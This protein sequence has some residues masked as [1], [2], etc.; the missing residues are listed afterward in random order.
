M[1]WGRFTAVG[2]AEAEAVTEAIVAEV[3]AA[4]RQAFSGPELRALLMLGGYGRGEGGVDRSGP[5]ERPHNNLDFLIVAEDSEGKRL[6]EL[7]ARLAATVAPIVQKHGI[8]MDTGATTVGR[9]RRAPSL[10]LWY[11][12]RFGHKTILG[13]ADLMPGMTHFRL[14]RIPAWDARNLLTNRGTLLLINAAVLEQDRPLD[15]ERRRLLVRHVMKA[16][17]GY[18]DALLFFLGDFHWSYLEKRRRMGLQAAVSPEFRALYDE[19]AG[20]RF[21]PRYEPYLERDFVA[22]M[23]AVRAALE[24]VHRLCEG[25]R[26]GRPGL[27]WSDYPALALRRALID[28]AASPRAWAVK[29]AHVA[30]SLRDRGLSGFG[31]PLRELALRVG[32]ARGAMPI[33][34]PTVAYALD[35]PALVA[36]AQHVLRAPS[37]DLP[38]LRR[39]Y[40]AGWARHGDINFATLVQK[41]GLDLGPAG[42]AP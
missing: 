2:S 16:V 13:D 37:R 25:R 31:T 28:D 40:L 1:S 39:A 11:D 20:F 26:L 15:A 3:A 35:D 10:I 34:F 22:W 12:M 42:A 30:R 38:A 4:V 23:N 7:R 19:A 27:T 24:P 14:E 33:V 21:E 36:L 18:G 9:L 5:V 32:G 6:P 8:G 17:I 41:L 29:A